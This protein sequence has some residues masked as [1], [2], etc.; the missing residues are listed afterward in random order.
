MEVRAAVSETLSVDVLLGTNVPELPD[1]LHTDSS[2]D[3][4]AV[5][6]RAQRH[7]MLTEEMDTRQK[8]RSQELPALVWTKST[9]GCPA[10]IM[11]SLAEDGPEPNNPGLRNVQ[12][13]TP[14]PRTWQKVMT[15]L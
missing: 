15:R 9:G 1:L 8:E 10:L 3:A 12:N 13:N 11:I 7:Q 6:T 2:T 14:M 4:M 5:M